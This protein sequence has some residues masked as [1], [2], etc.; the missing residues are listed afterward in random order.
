MLYSFKFRVELL[1]W[2]VHFFKLPGRVQSTSK[3]RTSSDFGQITLVWFETGHFKPNVQNP[4]FFTSLDRYIYLY[5]YDSKSPQRSMLSE[6]VW[7]SDRNHANLGDFFG[8][9]WA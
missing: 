1:A 3:I 8:R 7:I 2:T 4:N 6:G 5:S 9:N